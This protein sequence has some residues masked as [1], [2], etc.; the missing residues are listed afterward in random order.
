MSQSLQAQQFERLLDQH[1]AI[2]YKVSRTYAAYE[3]DDLAQEIA[4]QLWR[5]FPSFDPSRSK[6]STWM[7][8]VAL[9]TAISFQRRERLRAHKPLDEEL[10]T[11]PPRADPNLHDELRMLR[12]WIANLERPVDKALVL[13]FLEGESH[14]GIAEILGISESNAATK[15]ARLKENMRKDLTGK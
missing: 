11:L 13:L 10:L 3:P 2:L 5:S 6:F 14:R 12:E 4:I 15:L 1:K 9:N 7:Y 8:R